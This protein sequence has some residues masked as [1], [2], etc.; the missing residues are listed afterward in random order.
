[1]NW[2]ETQSAVQTMPAIAITKNMPVVPESPNRTSTTDVMM[3]VSMVMPE[4]G[5]LAVV[6]MALAATDAKKKAKSSVSA[7]PQMRMVHETWK[8]EKKIATARALRTMPR[9]IVTM[10][11]SRSVRA[12]S[13]AVCVRAE[14][15]WNARRAMPN[16]PAITRSDLATPKIPAVAMAPTPM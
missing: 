11:M 16:E 10:E 6:A 3:T 13:A 2:P 4:A 14:R 8:R 15:G 1:M 9:R 12:N 7:S 5:L